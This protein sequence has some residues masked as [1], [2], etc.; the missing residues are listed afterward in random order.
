[1]KLIAVCFLILVVSAAGCMSGPQVVEGTSS[2]TLSTPGSTLL[3]IRPT[4]TSTTAIS[5]D[6]E[7]E[8]TT[9]TIRLPA[10]ITNCLTLGNT[11]LRDYCFYDAAGRAKDIGTC[12]KITAKNLQLKCRAR[13]EDNSA[14]C[15]E[16]DTWSEKDWCYWM[17]AFRWNNI[18]Y[19]NVIFGQQIKDKCTLD[20]VRDKKAD[21]LKCFDLY[22][23]RMK[24]EC[25]LFHIDLYNRT[26][27]GIKPTLCTLIGN[28]TMQRQCNETYLRKP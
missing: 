17:M 18:K 4:T 7:E 14:Y 5:G 25:I 22:N 1:M 16:I 9:T 8:S 10:N 24:D 12:D 3:T 20:Y 15:D 28:A 6:Y 26:G 19:C 2:T 23:P 27:T 21:P 13:M 11:T